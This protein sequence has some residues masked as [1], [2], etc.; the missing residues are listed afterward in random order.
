MENTL[1]EASKWKNI[2]IMMDFFQHC[3]FDNQEKTDPRNTK[4]FLLSQ[5]KFRGSWFWS[6]GYIEELDLF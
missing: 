3:V 5:G 4:R 2:H 6:L 1:A